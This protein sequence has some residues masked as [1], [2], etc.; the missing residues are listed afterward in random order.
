[1]HDNLQPDN[2]LYPTRKNILRTM[3]QFVQ[4]V[5]DRETLFLMYSGHGSYIPCF[6]NPREPENQE[7]TICPV[8]YESS[9]MIADDI[10]RLTLL[11]PMLPQSAHFRA[12]FD[13]CHSGTMLNLRQNVR[14]DADKIKYV[15]TSNPYIPPTHCLDVQMISGCGDQETSADILSGPNTGGALTKAILWYVDSHKDHDKR[16]NLLMKKL[17]RGISEWLHQNGYEQRPEWS[18]GI[19]S[20]L[21]GHSY[22]LT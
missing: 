5:E 16:G 9:G 20:S 7:E 17:L 19:E 15:K 13:C 21:D 22:F 2:H 8:D 12:V 6:N 1:M 4:H 10:L 18:S 14:W 11:T 3:K